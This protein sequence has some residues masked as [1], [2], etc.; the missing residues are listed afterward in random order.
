MEQGLAAMALQESSTYKDI[1]SKAAQDQSRNN[2]GSS[3]GGNTGST[4]L[5]STGTGSTNLGILGK[6]KPARVVKV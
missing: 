2:L 3:A 5:S 6:P 4:A 1:K